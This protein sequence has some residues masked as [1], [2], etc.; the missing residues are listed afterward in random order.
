MKAYNRLG[1]LCGAAAVL[2]AITGNDVLATPPGPQVAHPTAAQDLAHLNWVASN[3]GA[4]IGIS[5]ELA[6]FAFL[7][8]FVAYVSTRVR[9]AGWLAAAALAGGVIEIAVKLGSGA[10]MFAAYMLRDEIS[11]TTARMLIE[12]NGA[13][14]VLTWIPEGIFVACAASAA[15]RTGDLGRILGWGGVV[16]GLE[17][18]IVTAATGVHVLNSIPVPFI[19]C[20]LW[21]LLVSLKWGLARASRIT[22][23]VVEAEMLAGV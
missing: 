2:A 20:L 23:P 4:Q 22:T 1:A 8:L 17:A 11:P 19:L 10:P 16:V 13:A 14:F 21:T 15:M 3:T 12:M 6:S 18:V 9:D 7:L 5:V